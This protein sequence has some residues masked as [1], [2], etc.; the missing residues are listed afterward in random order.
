MNIQSHLKVL[1]QKNEY[2]RDPFVIFR[3]F[4]GLFFLLSLE[5]NV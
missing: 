2:I 5:E 3:R 1:A 4:M